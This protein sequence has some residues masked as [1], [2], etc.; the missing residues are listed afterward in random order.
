[1]VVLSFERFNGLVAQMSVLP[2]VHVVMRLERVRDFVVALLQRV[3]V[4]LLLR[5]QW[6][7]LGVQLRELVM[8]V[9]VEL[10]ARFDPSPA[11]GLDG[12][13]LAG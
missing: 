6:G 12:F 13:D 9:V 5:V 10:R 11:F 2:F 1:L 7:R 3:E 4:L 8:L